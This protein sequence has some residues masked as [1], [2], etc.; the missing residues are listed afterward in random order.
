MV[1]SEVIQDALEH[2][3]NNQDIGV[4]YFRREKSGFC[5]SVPVNEQFEEIP[6]GE[7]YRISVGPSIWKKD[8]LLNSLKEEYSAWDFERIGSYSEETKSFRV[9][10]STDYE[11]YYLFIPDGAITKGK[12]KREVHEFAEENNLQID[13]GTRP[14]MSRW[15]QFKYDTKSFIF[16]IN[17]RLVVTIQNL[18]YKIK[19]FR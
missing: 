10:I 5:R 18:L 11:T 1:K 16:N 13:Y 15:D 7:P 4:I 8:S 12:W 14:I 6:Y 17:P 2:M 3:E 9:L 19:K